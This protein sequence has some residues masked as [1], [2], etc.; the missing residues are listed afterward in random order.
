MLSRGITAED[1]VIIFFVILLLGI[2][3]SILLVV[4]GRVAIFLLEYFDLL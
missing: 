2:W 4:V 1:V 3:G